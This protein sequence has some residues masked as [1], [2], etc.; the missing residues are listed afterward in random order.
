LV[1]PYGLENRANPPF[2]GT[3]QHSETGIINAVADEIIE[4]KVNGQAR[5]MTMFEAN[6]RALAH[7]GTRN[8]VAAQRFIELATSTSAAD[9]QMRLINHQFHEHMDRLEEENEKLRRATGQ[10]SST[11][12][13]PVD[14]LTGWDPHRRLDD[15]EGVAVVISGRSPAEP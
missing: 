1:P 3:D 10:R 9:L 14:D 11:V 8:R 2:P 5:K 13:V 15:E 12:Y 4:V 6:V 7:D